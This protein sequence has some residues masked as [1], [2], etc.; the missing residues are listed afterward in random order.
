MDDELLHEQALRTTVQLVVGERCALSASSGLIN[1][2]P[3][4]VTAALA[5]T[6]NGIELTAA[7][8]GLD[9]IVR[10]HDANDC[11]YFT[12]QELG[13]DQSV[14]GI[15]LTGEDVNPVKPEGLF[16]NLIALRNAMLSNDSEAIS[17]ATA[18]VD[19]DRK[20]IVNMRGVVGSQMRALEDRQIRIEDNIIALKTLR[21]DIQ[22]IDE[23]DVGDD[24][25]NQDL[26][27][28]MGRKN[29]DKDTQSR[30]DNRAD[31]FPLP[32][33]KDETPHAEGKK[34]K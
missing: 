11:G 21:S 5:T 32:G 9:L 29:E 33:N 14:S 22:D 27:N 6:G 26:V 23:Q 13:L 19:E 12:A 28:L 3:V 8:G 17:N 18:A 2:A 10:T 24:G 20:T 31:D 15:T 4:L 25:E 30:E 1:A 7:P 16:S 34:K